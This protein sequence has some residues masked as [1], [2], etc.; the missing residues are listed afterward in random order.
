MTE[1]WLNFAVVVLVALFLYIL[2]AIYSRKK[3]SDACHILLL[4][5]I[6]GAMIG[7]LSDLL[8]GKYLGLWT[9]SLGYTLLPLIL[10]ATLV[11]GLFSGSVLLMQKMS[12]LPFSLLVVLLMGVY[13]IANVFLGVWTYTLNLSL[14]GLLLFL[15]IGNLAMALCIATIWHFFLGRKF[16]AVAEL[17]NKFKTFYENAR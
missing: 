16:E 4:G 5:I 8:W 7:T 3:I 11:W 13:E 15:L 2:I 14:P 9:Y 12:L 1:S 17:E 6:T 10:N